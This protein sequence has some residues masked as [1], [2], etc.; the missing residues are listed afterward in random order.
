MYL[1]LFFFLSSIVARSL[2]L[3]SG[4]TGALAMDALVSE[5]TLSLLLAGL[6]QGLLRW[7]RGA[8]VLLCAAYSMLLVANMESI[9]ALNKG[10]DLRDIHYLFDAGFVAAS[11]AH[12]SYPIFTGLLVLAAALVCWR[13]QV[14]TIGSRALAVS[15]LAAFVFLLLSSSAQWQHNQI[16]L[17]GFVRA[18]TT[19]DNT[20]SDSDQ[21]AP[22]L[23]RDL[24]GTT[25]LGENRA[26]NIVV[27][28]LEGVSEHDLTSSMPNLASLGRAGSVAEHMYTHSNQTIRGLYALLCGDYS[29]LSLD[30]TKAAEYLQL[31]LQQRPLCLPGALAQAGYY[32]SYLQAAP[33]AYMG[34]DVFMPAI[35]FSQVLGEESLPRRYADVGWGPDD[36]AFL[37][38]AAEHIDSLHQRQ[39][40][41]FT[42]LLTV[43]THHPYT[44]PDDQRGSE[45]KQAARRYLDA[46]LPAFYNTL[47]AQG[48]WQDTLLIITSDES[49]NSNR[50][51][52]LARG[53][54]IPAGRLQ[55]VHGLLDIPVSVLDYLQLA[56]QFPDFGGRSL[57]RHYQRP[58]PLLFF[59]DQFYAITHNRELLFCESEQ[60]CSRGELDAERQL[61][62]ALPADEAKAQYQQLQRWRQQADASLRI[63][64]VG[65]SLTVLQDRQFPVASGQL[66]VLAA[67]KYL[68]LPAGRRASLRLDISYRGSG[69][70][71]VRPDLVDSDNSV[72][73][74]PGL[75]IPLLHNGQ[76]LQWQQQ[77]IVVEPVATA[78]PTL[79][80]PVQRGAGQLQVDLFAVTLDDETEIAPTLRRSTL[81]TSIGHAGGRWNDIDYTNSN[82]AL[83]QNGP[84]LPLMELDISLTADGKLVCLHDWG[85]GYQ[86]L[87]KQKVSAPLSYRQFNAKLENS[88]LPFSPCSETSLPTILDEQPGLRLVI[89]SWS[90]SEAIMQRLLLV[91]PAAA[92]RIIPQ[93]YS[94][95]E[96]IRFREMGF[97]DVIWTLYRYPRRGDFPHVLATARKLTPWA[98]TLPLE[99]AD[100]SLIAELLLTGSLVYVHTIND[101]D[102]ALPLWRQGASIYSDTLQNGDCQSRE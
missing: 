84:R 81:A 31:S 23:Q 26:R 36:K 4:A 38:Q 88:S 93:A 59:S 99:S 17:P 48:V 80:T 65:E 49:H 5:L 6:G 90:D 44:L 34:K 89:D 1:F 24:A 43:G 85:L 92:R 11:T 79:L 14:L 101:C 68:R 16:I 54:G 15:T 52:W 67:G 98:V 91:I 69:A 64:S 33:L 86:A 20:D 7:Q 19:G 21:P 56:D 74:L 25:M 78:Q 61:A 8:L 82:E 100:D 9:V 45:P 18:W 66:N 60:A 102:T 41:F 29:K 72:S 58:R 75:Q 73:L 71:S 53:P 46:A 28:V 77:I 97:E 10:V 2:L 32:T 13:E 47:S 87:F 62:T 55:Q 37:E 27:L 42:T 57:F 39:Q 51:L 30:T 35:G 83:R 50:G 70:V 12:F 22:G 96:I 76:R 94:P 40:P 63:S 3:P 95:E